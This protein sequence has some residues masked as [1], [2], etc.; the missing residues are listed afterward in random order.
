MET[1]NEIQEMFKT[2]K[3]SLIQIVRENVEQYAPIKSTVENLGNL[4][5]TMA[6]LI[7]NIFEE[8]N[9]SRTQMF[10]ICENIA[11]YENSSKRD[12][13]RERKKQK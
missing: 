10:D 1:L 2:V 12:K 11:V 3:A 6:I 4:S 5:N 13:K 8:I 7:G 9:E